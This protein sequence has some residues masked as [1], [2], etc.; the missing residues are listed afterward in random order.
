V[1]VCVCVGH[2]RESCK[3]GQTE[4]DAVL[5][6]T[7]VGQRNDELDKV[8]YGRHLVNTT[9]RSVHGGDEDCRYYTA[10]CLILVW[11]LYKFTEAYRPYSGAAYGSRD[12]R[13]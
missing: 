11:T 3:N 5:G 12:N 8:T 9:E 2:D 13:L 1:C 6:Q 10:T 4:R 7:G